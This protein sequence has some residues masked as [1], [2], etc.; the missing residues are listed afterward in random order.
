MAQ[1]IREVGR[2]NLIVEYYKERRNVALFR[3]FKQMWIRRTKGS[4][5]DHIAKATMS[6]LDDATNRLKNDA[7]RFDHDLLAYF[8]MGYVL[9]HKYEPVTVYT[10]DD[11]DE[12]LSRLAVFH[13]IMRFTWEE[14][15]YIDG[16]GPLPAQP[17][18]RFRFVSNAGIITREISYHELAK[19]LLKE[20]L[21]K[22]A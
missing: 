5:E 6:R 21:V 22:R 11:P 2:I 8:L 17:A 20:G 15:A 13:I 3:G 18:A 12:V 10:Q 14:W 16:V 9:D 1:I 4:H 19:F 7:D